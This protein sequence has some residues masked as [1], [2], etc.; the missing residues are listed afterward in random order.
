MNSQI[1]SALSSRV[2]S[3]KG[4]TSGIGILS[5]DKKGRAVFLSHSCRE[6]V[7]S[8][9]TVV[10]QEQ[11]RIFRE[12]N[13]LERCVRFFSRSQPCYR[14]DFGEDPALYPLHRERA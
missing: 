11:S 7:L 2:F 9:Y 4:G 10:S 14:E 3:H 6:A 8:L 5:D 1:G 13:S 12:R